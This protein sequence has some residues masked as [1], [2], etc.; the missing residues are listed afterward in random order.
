MAQL[1]QELDPIVKDAIAVTQTQASLRLEQSIM[2]LRESVEALRDSTRIL[3]GTVTQ[4]GTNLGKR[5]T[6]LDKRL[7][8]RSD[9]LEK[10]LVNGLEELGKKSDKYFSALAQVS[11][12]S[13]L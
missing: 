13:S 2:T 11:L 1:R 6:D 4:Q 3:E 7:M 5:I 12:F 9:D 10:K 8:K